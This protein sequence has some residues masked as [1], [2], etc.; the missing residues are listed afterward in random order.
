MD[1]DSLIEKGVASFPEIPTFDFLI[2]WLLIYF[3]IIWKLRL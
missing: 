1:S 2:T 3:L